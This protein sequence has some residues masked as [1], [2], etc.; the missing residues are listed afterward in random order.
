MF[1]ESYP[2]VQPS[3]NYLFIFQESITGADPTDIEL[4]KLCS[5]LVYV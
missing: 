1:A 5:L 2:Y 3:W 4:A